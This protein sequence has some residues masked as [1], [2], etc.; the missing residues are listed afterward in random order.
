M[1]VR[2]VTGAGAPLPGQEG[3]GP[4]T[5]LRPG[6][7]LV[8]KVL[9]ANGRMAR[10][11]LG[12]RTMDVQTAVPLSRGDE[13]RVKVAAGP[14]GQIQLQVQALQGKGSLLDDPH[15]ADLLE[16]MGLPTD[17][18][19]L[20][21]ARSLLE[22]SQSVQPG[23]VRELARLFA[24]LGTAE[25]RAAA[26]FL[27]ARCLPATPGA[28]ALVA[29][30]PGDPATAGKRV[31]DRLEALKRKAPELLDFLGALGALDLGDAADAGEL[32]EALRHL[33]SS[34]NPPEAEILSYLRDRQGDLGERLS[35]NLSAWLDRFAQESAQPQAQAAAKELGAEIRFQQ[36]ADVAGA[37]N[38]NPSE[39]RL[40]LILA[41]STGDL[42]IQH[43]QGNARDTAFQARVLLNL[44]MPELGRVAI[45]LMYSRG[46]VGGRLTVGDEDVR[47]FLADRLGELQTGLGKIGI[48]VSH[49]EVGMPREPA[50]QEQVPG[51]FDLRL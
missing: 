22:Q 1:D 38:L 51:R 5:S 23:Q 28:I 19:S 43:W 44:D 33:A 49:L 18:A 27:V 26:A 9:E 12:G 15:I 34:L 25:E 8:G 21:A 3:D 6:Q 16:K 35:R 47:A 4:A 7:I 50:S 24:T 37:A 36:L 39:I 45:D 14:G 13:L 20:A 46:T 42:T 32:E 48:G 2:P 10:V 40:P 31:A 30:R 17:K 41:G 29:G 11:D